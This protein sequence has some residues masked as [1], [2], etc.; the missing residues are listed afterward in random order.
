MEQLVGLERIDDNE[1][2]KT[3]RYN[4][5]A[6]MKSYLNMNG[7]KFT[8]QIFYSKYQFELYSNFYIFLND[9][10]NGGNSPKKIEIC[11]VL[12][13]LRKIYKKNFGLKSE[14]VAVNTIA[15]WWCKWFRTFQNQDRN[16]TTEVLKFGDVNEMNLG[17]FGVKKLLKSK[18]WYYAFLSDLDYFDNQL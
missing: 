14:T 13:Q 3:S 12:I 18:F 4:F 9:P 6:N 17:A 7:G 8:N 1:G 2:G 16:I 11:M 5:T 10:I 15:L